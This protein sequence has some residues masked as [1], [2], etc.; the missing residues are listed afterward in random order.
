MHQRLEL[1][2][3]SPKFLIKFSPAEP[4]TNDFSHLARSQRCIS[5]MHIQTLYVCLVSIERSA[6]KGQ[7]SGAPWAL[8]HSQGTSPPALLGMLSLGAP[9]EGRRNISPP[10]ALRVGMVISCWEVLKVSV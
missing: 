1:S 2:G 10:T 9:A 6:D 7:Q 4:V 3:Q 5:H 8:G